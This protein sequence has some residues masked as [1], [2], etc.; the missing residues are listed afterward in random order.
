MLHFNSVSF[1][2]RDRF[3]QVRLCLGGELSLARTV[4]VPRRTGT[5]KGSVVETE[6]GNEWHFSLTR[7]NACVKT[8]SKSELEY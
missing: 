5:N 3:A 7:M 1:R 2:S 4:H 8:S 6:G